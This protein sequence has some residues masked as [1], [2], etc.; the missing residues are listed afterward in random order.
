MQNKFDILDGDDEPVFS[1][2]V[3]YEGKLIAK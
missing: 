3:E 1:I 2:E